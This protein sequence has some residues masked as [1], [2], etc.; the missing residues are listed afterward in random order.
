MD[1]YRIEKDGEIG[2]MELEANKPDEMI[3]LLVKN[4]Y[5]VEKITLEEFNQL[6]GKSK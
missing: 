2:T 3:S 5:G 4:G 6:E 1:Y